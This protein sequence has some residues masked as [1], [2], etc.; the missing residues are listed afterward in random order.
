MTREVGV[1]AAD[2]HGAGL[3]VRRAGGPEQRS[4][5]VLET[6]GLDDWHG[7]SSFEPARERVLLV[8]AGRMVSKRWSDGNDLTAENWLGA[9]QLGGVSAAAARSRARRH[10]NA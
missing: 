5:D 2:R 9:T 7:V 10:P 4:T 6:V 8:V 1:D 3:L